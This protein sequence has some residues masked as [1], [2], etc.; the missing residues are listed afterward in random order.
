MYE[1]RS[2]A[3]AVMSGA[4]TL[5]LNPVKLGN[6][7]KGYS[8]MRLK[9]GLAE[10]PVRIVISGRATIDPSAEIFKHRF[11]PIVVLVSQSAPEKR[12]KRLRALADEVA[13]FGKKEIDFAQ[14]VRWL[15]TRWNVR[16][17]LC[18]GG[19][20]V[21]GALFKAGLVNE[22][23]VTLCPVILGGR[24]APTLA[25]GEG[26]QLLAEATQLKLRSMKRL[27]DEFFLIYRVICP[28]A[29]Q[30]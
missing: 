21:N 26:V 1:L 11:S 10:H 2:Y 28:A 19:G 7:G 24:D 22:L 6:G 12:V 27:G 9:L 5:D 17:L 4:R 8:R 14:A 23:Y 20:E 25:D 16:S 30:V 29:N 15:R 18:E 13:T 3:D